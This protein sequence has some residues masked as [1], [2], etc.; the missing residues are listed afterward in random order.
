MTPYKVTCFT[1]YFWFLAYSRSIHSFLEMP[2]NFLSC[3]ANWSCF[4]CL[5]CLAYSLLSSLKLL[6]LLELFASQASQVSK[7]N[8]YTHSYTAITLSP[9]FHF[10]LPCL[11]KVWFVMGITQGWYH[12]GSNQASNFK[13]GRACSPRSIW[14]YE[15][16]YSLKCTTWGPI[17]NQ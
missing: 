13:M 9:S 7:V 16:D 2:M 1:A 11:L 15:H 17:T 5:S 14:N 10:K 12:S 4:T 3:F 6:S 8:M